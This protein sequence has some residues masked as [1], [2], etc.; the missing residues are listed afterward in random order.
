MDTLIAYT[1]TTYIKGR[2]ILD[3]IMRVNETL[4]SIK[5]QKIPSFL[6]KIDFEKAFDKIS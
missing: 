3:N 5:K 6:F 1:Q 4:H 2:Y